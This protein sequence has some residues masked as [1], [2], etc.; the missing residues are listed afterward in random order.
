VD[1]A[2]FH[3]RS[4]RAVIRVYDDAGKV[5]EAQEHG[6]S[7]SRRRLSFIRVRMRLRLILG[8]RGLDLLIF[9]V[10]DHVAKFAFFTR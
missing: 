5:I 1:V 4:H 6:S 7:K 8:I 3:S 9:L 10:E 2:K